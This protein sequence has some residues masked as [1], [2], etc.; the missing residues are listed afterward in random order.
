AVRP[1]V[2]F[3]EAMGAS[4]VTIATVRLLGPGGTPV[5]QAA[6]SPSLDASGTV[7]TITLAASLASST[8]YQVQVVGGASGVKDAAGNALAATYQQATGFR[9]AEPPD[10]TPPTVASA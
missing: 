6:G 10:T 7:V 1:T 8:T 3:S 9:T 5:A 2:T 4:S